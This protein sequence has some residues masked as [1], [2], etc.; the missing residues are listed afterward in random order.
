M[1]HELFPSHPNAGT[2]PWLISQGAKK[3]HD[4]VFINLNQRSYTYAEIDSLSDE[5]LAF[6]RPNGYHTKYRLW[7]KPC[8]S[9]EYAVV[10]L[11]GLKSGMEIISEKL[12]NKACDQISESSKQLMIFE[13][14][15]F[16]NGSKSI[17][18]TKAKQLGRQE[19]FYN[20]P[21]LNEES[22]VFFIDCPQNKQYPEIISQ[23]QAYAISSNSLGE[24]QQHSFINFL[25]K[26][27]NGNSI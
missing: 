25:Y 21:Q 9:V 6:F 1:L 26:W 12:I 7:L 14:E 2:I 16:F 20:I 11:A 10:F 17:T 18:Y 19:L 23:K 13:N 3:H 5:L 4:K 27:I 24:G 8:K 22:A 15:Q